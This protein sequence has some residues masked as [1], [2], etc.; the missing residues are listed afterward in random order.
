MHIFALARTQLTMYVGL[1]PVLPGLTTSQIYCESLVMEAPFSQ[2]KLLVFPEVGFHDW[3]RFVVNKL[4]YFF[5]PI[6][7]MIVWHTDYWS[8]SEKTIL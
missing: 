8:P 3:T 5:V 1:G 2:P 4:V 7:K 6:S